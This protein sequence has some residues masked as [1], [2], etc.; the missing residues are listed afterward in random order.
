MNSGRGM[1]VPVGS[2]FSQDQSIHHLES[3]SNVLHHMVEKIV[4]FV[5]LCWLVGSCGSLTCVLTLDCV[6]RGRWTETYRYHN[7]SSV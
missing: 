3:P 2:W 4:D 7:N 6:L 5:D 1:L